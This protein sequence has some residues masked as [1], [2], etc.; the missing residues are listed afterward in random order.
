[1]NHSLVLCLLS[2]ALLPLLS[3]CG[4]NNT[5]ED[6]DPLNTAIIEG[7]GWS[8]TSIQFSDNSASAIYDTI[9]D[10]TTCQIEG[11][12]TGAKPVAGN[13]E[14]VTLLLRFKGKV[15]G[16]FDWISIAKEIR[17]YPVVLFIGDEPYTQKGGSLT[18]TEY[19]E[20]GHRISCT[21]SGSLQNS[22]GDAIVTLEE[23]SFSAIR[24]EDTGDPY[25]DSPLSFILDGDGYNNVEVVKIDK[26]FKTVGAVRYETGGGPHLSFILTAGSLEVPGHGSHSFSFIFRY[27]GSYEG[28]W[29]WNLGVNSDFTMTIDNEVY[30]GTEGRTG[31]SYYGRSVSERVVGYFDGTLKSRTTG[32]V[33]RIKSGRYVTVRFN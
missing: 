32:A 3:S 29:P 31:V 21:F 16:T 10:V 17:D 13:E 19:G 24:G 23:G 12:L 6:V 20:A 26:V 15:P 8:R 2:L 7:D 18:V 28:V 5:V 1:M 11:T 9:T 30:E 4:E 14:E 22:S 33:I 25:A 27:P